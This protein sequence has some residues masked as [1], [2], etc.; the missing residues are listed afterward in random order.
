MRRG[1]QTNLLLS[2]SHFFGS[3]RSSQDAALW[4]R[5]FG[6]LVQITHRGS[7]LHVTGH[8]YYPLQLPS[9]LLLQSSWAAD[10]LRCSF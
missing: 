2:N 7:A 3:S 9:L 1:G 4:R 8:L 10:L 5:G 6:S